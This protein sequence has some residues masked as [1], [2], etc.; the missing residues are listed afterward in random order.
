MSLPVLLPLAFLLGSIPF[1][2]LVAK[3][4]G[5][6]IL[7]AGSGNIGAT[8]VLRVLGPGA[9]ILVLLLDTLKGWLP[10]WSGAYFLNSNEASLWL[11]LAAVLGHTFSPFLKFKGGKGVATTLGL[12]IGTTPIAAGIATVI[13]ASVVASTRY[14]SLASILSGLS[15]P[16]TAYLSHS[17][18]VVVVVYGL[19]AAFLI[20]KHRDNIKRLRAGTENK[21]GRKQS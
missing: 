18:P 19:I 7:T 5:V 6:D 12:V 2:Y 1:G 11:G 13:F 15:L 21:I 17:S 4:K 14:V 10:A 3:A 16:I 9:G 20:Y 8:N